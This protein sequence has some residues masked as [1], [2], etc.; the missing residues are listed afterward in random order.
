MQTLSDRL[1]SAL[2]EAL[3]E[4]GRQDAELRQAMRCSLLW[5]QAHSSEGQ[6]QGNIQSGRVWQC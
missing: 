3:S 5:P 4:A 6:W 1:G 2:G